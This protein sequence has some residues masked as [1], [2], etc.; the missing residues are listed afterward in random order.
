MACLCTFDQLFVVGNSEARHDHKHSG[1][2]P[3]ATVLLYRWHLPKRAWQK[4]FVATRTICN[5]TP[6]AHLEFR[7]R[8]LSTDPE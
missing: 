8:S 2:T 1:A 6:C 3:R 5:C 4:R 7:R